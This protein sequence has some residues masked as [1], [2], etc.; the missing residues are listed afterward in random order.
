MYDIIIRGDR[1]WMIIVS[2]LA[3]VLVG[4]LGIVPKKYMRFNSRFQQAGVILLLFSMGASIGANRELILK[5]KSIG[6]KS[7][8][9]AL[10]ACLFSILFTY[11]VTSKFLGQRREGNK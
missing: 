10:L 2:L 3:G 4:L 6:L 7:I 8:T 9:F 11:L 5:L 1:M